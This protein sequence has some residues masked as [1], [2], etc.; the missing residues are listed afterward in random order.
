MYVF[1]YSNLLRQNFNSIA[2]NEVDISSWELHTR[3][4]FQIKIFDHIFYVIYKAIFSNGDVNIS[5]QLM[6]GQQICK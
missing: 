1:I 5:F 4:Y 6:S 3:R 2:F